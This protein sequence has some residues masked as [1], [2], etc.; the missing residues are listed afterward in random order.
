MSRVNND[1]RW[2]PSCKCTFLDLATSD[3]ALC[4][5]AHYFVFLL[6]TIIKRMRF[7]Q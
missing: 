5:V 7:E 4:E 6:S 1:S 2:R 3:Q